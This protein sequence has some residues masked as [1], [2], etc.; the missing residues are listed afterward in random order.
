MSIGASMFGRGE[1]IVFGEMEY[2][3]CLSETS[4]GGANEASLPIGEISGNSPDDPCEK[5]S[6]CGAL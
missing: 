1:G 3:E 5:C 6:V 2:E 4:E